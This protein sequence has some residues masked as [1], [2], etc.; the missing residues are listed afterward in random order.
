MR[1]YGDH[2]NQEFVH[3]GTVTFAMLIFRLFQQHC[4]GLQRILAEAVFRNHNKSIGA[5]SHS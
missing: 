3:N 4:P 2:R 5:H 1:L